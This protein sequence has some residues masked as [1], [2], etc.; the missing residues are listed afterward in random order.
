MNLKD[1]I[2]TIPNVLPADE[3]YEILDYCEGTTDFQ[4]QEKSPPNGEVNTG[5]Q[6]GK[7]FDIKLD[8]GRIHDLIRKSFLFGL[9]E[10]LPHYDYLI[11][12]NFYRVTSG[13]WLLKYIE[14]DFLSCHTDFQ[15][16]SGSLTMSYCI[17][18][19]Y[20]GGELVFWK[21][22]KIPNQKNCLHIFPSCF[23]YP[24]EVLPITK[25][26]RYSAIT[27][28]GHERAARDI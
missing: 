6:Y 23:L 12:P 22:Y 1:Y 15:A 11:P 18:D 4:R 28:F 24:H 27:W 13:Y 2:I 21:N 10:S 17:N 26:I 19:N 5:D 9:K 7:R 8:F 16:E 25:G 14:G 3:Y 20:E